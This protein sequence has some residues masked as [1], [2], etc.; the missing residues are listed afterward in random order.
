LTSSTARVFPFQVLVPANQ[1][2]IRV[3]SKA[4]ADQVR[5][6]AIERVG[7]A[8]GEVPASTM[9]GIDD[10]LRLHLDL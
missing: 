2:G 7:P 9:D 1:G 10:A 8:L 6:V 4:Q 5:S 3:D